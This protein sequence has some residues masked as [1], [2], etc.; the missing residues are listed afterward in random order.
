MSEQYVKTYLDCGA[1][2]E[3]DVIVQFDH[4]PFEPTVIH[5][6]DDA[7]EGCAESAEITSVIAILDG[8]EVQIMDKIAAYDISLLEE[9]AMESLDG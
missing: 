9:A 4:Q 5:P 3:L 7:Y 6:V 2:G 8:I 1:L